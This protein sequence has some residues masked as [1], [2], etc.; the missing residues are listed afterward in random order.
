MVNWLRSLYRRLRALLP[1]RRWFTS[2]AWVAEADELPD[3][4]LKRRIYLVGSPARPKWAAFACPCESGHTITLNLQ[5]KRRPSWR[6]STRDGVS[7]WPSVDVR[8]RRRCHFWVRHSRI[9]WAADAPR[10]REASSAD[11]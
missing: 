2:L 11:A 9:Y 7:L 6:V 10:P 1:R 8:E 4:M 5:S 3:T